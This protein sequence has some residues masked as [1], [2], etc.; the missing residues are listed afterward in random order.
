MAKG[1]SDMQDGLC[2]V[3]AGFLYEILVM[4]SERKDIKRAIRVVRRIFSGDSCK[5]SEILRRSLFTCKR[6]SNC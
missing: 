5:S 3:N 2:M 6:R 4:I 1:D